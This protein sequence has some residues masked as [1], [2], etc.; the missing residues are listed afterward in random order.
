[1]HGPVVH[2][3]QPFTRCPQQFWRDLVEYLRDVLRRIQVA[4][5]SDKR[6]CVSAR[7]GTTNHNAAPAMLF[8]LSGTSWISGLSG[9]P[10][11]SHGTIQNI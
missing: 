7:Y 5:N 1:M 9:Q 8:A 3:H 2:E 10:P 4:I 6:V 11:H